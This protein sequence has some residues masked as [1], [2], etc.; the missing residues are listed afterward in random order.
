MMQEP[1]QEAIERFQRV[2][3]MWYAIDSAHTADDLLLAGS[4]DCLAKSE[5]LARW[6]NG[7]GLETRFVRWRYLLPD[8]VAEVHQLPSRIDVHRTVE[9]RL[10]DRWLLVDATHDPA[11]ARGGLAVADWDGSSETP[12]AYPQ[13]GPRFVEGIDDAEMAQALV[14]ITRWTEACDPEVLARWRSAYVRWI[15][16]ARAV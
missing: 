5:L 12:I 16:Q 2:R 7:L 10:R 13:L 8:V 11:L 4:G 6:L 9:V 14:E 1:I 15:H 3:N